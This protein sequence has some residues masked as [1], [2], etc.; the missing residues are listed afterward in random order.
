MAYWTFFRNFYKKLGP[1]LITGASDDDP[2]GIATYSQAGAQFGLTMLWTAFFTLPLMVA[3]QEMCGRIGLVTGDGLTHIIQKHYPKWL[4]YLIMALT[5]PAIIL[6]IAADISSMGAVAHLLVPSIAPNTFCMVFM[7]I[8]AWAMIYLNYNQI[9]NLLKYFCLSL[10]LY[11]F[12]PFMTNTNWLAVIQATFIP[13]IHFDKDYLN[14]LVAILGTTIS[15]YLFFW[16]ATMAAEESKK[17]KRSLTTSIRESQF[18]VLVGMFSSNLVMFFIILTTASVLY[19][20]GIH[21]VD[22][23]EEAAKALEP[24][25]GSFAYTLFALGIL[26]TGF[27]TIPVLCGGFSYILS[28][29][30]KIKNGLNRQFNEAKVF[31]LIIIS[32]L[33]IALIINLI[34]LS[35]IKA[36][37]WTAILYGLISPVLIFLILLIS[38]NK[39][40]MKNQTN[41]ILSNILGGSGF[42]LMTFAAGLLIY[43]SFH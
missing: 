38:N 19:A 29:P 8:L 16:Q 42:I 21:Q 2:S 12:I 13:R 18:D 28:T 22:T 27:L 25:A 14:I 5:L 32:S 26:G 24:L 40:I 31:Y 20:H 17:G 15:P 33:L 6:N 23:V 4:L 3:I 11:L 1:G 43:Y 7:G 9:V 37:L 34:G 36:L 30:L 10:L 41:G 39:K 35:P